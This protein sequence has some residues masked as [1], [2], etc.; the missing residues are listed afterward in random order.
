MCAIGRYD[1]ERRP[2]DG[3]TSSVYAVQA[4]STLAW[5]SI[6]PLGRPVVPEV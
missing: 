1:T 5:V 4:A 2:S 3:P 6:T